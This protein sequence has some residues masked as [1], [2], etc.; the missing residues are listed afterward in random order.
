MIVQLVL[1]TCTLRARLVLQSCDSPAG[2]QKTCT[3]RTSKVAIFQP[4]LENCTSRAILALQSCDFP[5]RILH[6]SR[7]RLV[8]QSCDS[9][10][11][12]RATKLRFSSKS[13]KPVLC[14]LDLCYRVSIT[15]GAG[16]LMSRTDLCYKVAICQL[17]N[18]VLRVLDLCYKV[19][20]FSQS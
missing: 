10:A 6:T 11:R 3:S 2:A 18:P 14:A 8:L 19:V 7:A 5:A 17:E 13:W 20:I 4:E 1:K 12:A 9:P 15:A 16:N